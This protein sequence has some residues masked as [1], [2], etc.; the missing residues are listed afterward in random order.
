MAVR[1]ETIKP[2]D[3]L[4]QKK[5]IRQGNTTMK[6][7]IV[8]TVQVVTVDE[9]AADVIWNGCNKGRWSRSAMERLFRKN[10]KASA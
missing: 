9:F 5:R 1:Y 2:E 10:P 4:Y 3:V 6:K 7:D 8:Y